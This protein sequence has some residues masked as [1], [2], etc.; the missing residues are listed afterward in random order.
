MH[1]GVAL[2]CE[3]RRQPPRGQCAPPRRAGRASRRQHQRQLGQR[4]GGARG[5]RGTTKE[6]GD[7]TGAAALVPAPGRGASQ[8]VIII[9]QRMPVGRAEMCGGGGNGRGPT[10]AVHLSRPTARERKRSRPGDQG[11]AHSACRGRGWASRL[12][13]APLLLSRQ[14]S[15]AQRWAG[16]RAR[17]ASRACRPSLSPRRRCRCCRACRRRCEGWRGRAAQGLQCEKDGGGGG[18]A[19]AV[20]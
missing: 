10:C 13:L 8:R 12:G 1:S 17:G 3:P 6:I 15:A 11:G 20:L 2:G 16:R 9:G 4:E 18:R 19:P 14:R 5:R 7:R